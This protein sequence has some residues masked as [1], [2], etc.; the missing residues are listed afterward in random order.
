MSNHMRAI[1]G[2]GAWLIA[3][4]IQLVSSG[5]PELIRPH[6]YL[7]AGL[8]ILGTVMFAFPWLQRYFVS[9][10]RRLYPAPEPVKWPESLQWGNP[11]TEVSPE[12]R[13]EVSP[14]ISPS[15]E[16]S[17][18]IQ[19]EISPNM[20]QVFSPTINI[21]ERAQ[22]KEPE[23]PPPT[24]KPMPNLILR[25]PYKGYFENAGLIFKQ[26]DPPAGMLGLAIPV[27]N[28]E[29]DVGAQ[30]AVEAKGIAAVVRFSRDG[31]LLATM[32]RAYWM[33]IVQN[34][35]NIPIGETKGIVI[36]LY[37]PGTWLYYVN[38][39]K[40][41]IPAR[42]TPQQLQ[43]I[44]SQSAAQR[45]AYYLFLNPTLDVEVKLFS[46]YTGESFVKKT[47]KLSVSDADAYDFVCEEL[48]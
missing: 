3:L 35:I 23:P 1:A 45:Q 16:A 13:T 43:N 12:I 4:A 24:A 11:A 20:S 25:S 6:P 29:A 37:Q 42:I 18:N 21:G 31:E 41:G 22:P 26:L 27:E 5:W 48:E 14:T 36:G 44:A 46:I 8:A 33:N 32:S 38:G 10:Q 7:V 9:T 47:Y 40:D 28:V 15:I 2:G 34:Q 30:R 17:P 39:R 19:T